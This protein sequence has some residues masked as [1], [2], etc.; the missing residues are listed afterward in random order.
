MSATAPQH[1]GLAG[2]CYDDHLCPACEDATGEP[3]ADLFMHPICGLVA[4]GAD[5]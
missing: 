1:A 3:C 5:S 4:C 2:L